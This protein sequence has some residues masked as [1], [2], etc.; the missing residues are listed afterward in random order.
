MRRSRLWS[1]A[2]VGF[3]ILGAAA[4]LVTAIF[5]LFLFAYACAGTDVAS[6][7][8]DGTAGSALCAS[9]VYVW[10]AL[11]WLAVAGFALVAIPASLRRRS[12]RPM[13]LAWVSGLALVTLSIAL[14]LIVDAGRDSV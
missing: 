5:A 8:R 13:A 2:V 4:A 1:A 6:A 3:G 7:P 12:P 14:S 11:L 9:G 10:D